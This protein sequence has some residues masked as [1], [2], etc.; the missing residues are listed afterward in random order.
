MIPQVDPV[1]AIYFFASTHVSWRDE[2][3]LDFLGVGLHRATANP[4]E[5][6]CAQ[7]LSVNQCP[8]PKR[9][10]LYQLEENRHQ[11][12]DMDCRRNHPSHDWSRNR[13][14]YI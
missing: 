13:F 7:M 12:Q 4:R 11:N 1:G 3:L 10:L 14:H 9:T 8:A 5:M 6:V 2:G